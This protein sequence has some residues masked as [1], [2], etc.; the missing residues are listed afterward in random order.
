MSGNASTTQYATP[1]AGPGSLSTTGLFELSVHSWGVT[2][3]SLGALPVTRLFQIIGSQSKVVTDKV[4]A[5]ENSG[6]GTLSIATMFEL[7]LK[8]QRL[9]QMTE[10][11]T[12]LTTAISGCLQSV[13]RNTK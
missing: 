10:M 7:Q 12:S 5:I 2:E 13:A 11:A 6:S 8:T 1:Y 3:Q 4:I 9:C